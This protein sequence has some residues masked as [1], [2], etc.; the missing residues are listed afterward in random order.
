MTMTETDA[1]AH[2]NVLGIGVSRGC[3]VESRAPSPVHLVDVRADTEQ[4]VH[5]WQV[6]VGGS[7]VKGDPTGDVKMCIRQTM[8]R[9][10]FTESRV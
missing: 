7:I 4:Y 1:V 10:H 9:A 3:V 8:L 5:T 2:G 6:G